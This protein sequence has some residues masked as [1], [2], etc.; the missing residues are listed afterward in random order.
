MSVHHAKPLRRKGEE[1]DVKELFFFSSSLLL[2][3][4]SFLRCVLAALRE[5]YMARYYL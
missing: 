3:F 1:K 2:F 4:S 5:I